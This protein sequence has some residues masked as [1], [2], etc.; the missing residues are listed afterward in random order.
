MKL[1]IPYVCISFSIIIVDSHLF[2]CCHSVDVLHKVYLGSGIIR[3]HMITLN[4][5]QSYPNMACYE[6]TYEVNT[7]FT[8]L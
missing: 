1:S 7:G 4:W 8:I 3:E 6:R 5:Q 2:Q